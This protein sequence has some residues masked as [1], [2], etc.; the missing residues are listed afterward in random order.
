ML[1]HHAQIDEAIMSQVGIRWLKVAM[2][3]ARVEKVLEGKILG[4]DL[5]PA[6]DEGVEMR[7]ALL[8]TI[9][10]RVKFLVGQG[11][12]ERAGNL[13]NWRHGEVRLPPTA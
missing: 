12:L 4:P 6:S 2:F 1:D 7:D 11:R 13:S 8:D 10:E 5:N 3:V 9:A